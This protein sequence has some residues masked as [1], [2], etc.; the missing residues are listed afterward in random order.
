MCLKC[1]LFPCNVT[2]MCESDC[3]NCSKLLGHYV[4][5]LFNMLTRSITYKLLLIAVNMAMVKM[6]E[7]CQGNLHLK[8]KNI[9]RK[10]RQ[11]QKIEEPVLYC[12][13]CKEFFTITSKIEIGLNKDTIDKNQ[14]MWDGL[15]PTDFLRD[16]GVNS[17]TTDEELREKISI[18]FLLI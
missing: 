6:C 4:T 10:L 16:L 17:E 3:E 8:N 5:C 14:L 12:K 15:S 7:K 18:F 13:T 9:I 2:Y 1:S 11:S